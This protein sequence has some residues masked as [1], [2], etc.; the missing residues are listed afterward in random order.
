[1]C[2][3]TNFFSITRGFI[4]LLMTSQAYA[5]SPTIVDDVM[6]IVQDQEMKIPDNTV[7]SFIGE[8]KEGT[9]CNIKVAT[10]E[11]GWVSF[12]NIS[13]YFF[14]Y[15]N[16]FSS[17]LETITDKMKYGTVDLLE[18]N[19]YTDI[20]YRAHI[21]HAGITLRSNIEATYG[22]VKL[23]GYKLEELQSAAFLTK[24]LSTNLNWSCSNLEKIEPSSSY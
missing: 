16:A 12:L 21:F 5:S 7:L 4:A 13:G 23:Y 3:R 10:D 2:K 9:P 15:D 17:S 11:D 22:E 14:G 20:E 8:D 18:S 6:S 24:G 19:I 1:M